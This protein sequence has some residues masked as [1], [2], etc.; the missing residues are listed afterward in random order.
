MIKRADSSLTIKNDTVVA[1]QTGL[2]I[3]I[4]ENDIKKGCLGCQDSFQAIQFLSP[5]FFI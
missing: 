3:I 4:K 2:I 1:G 5:S